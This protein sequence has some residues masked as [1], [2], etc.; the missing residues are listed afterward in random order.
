M[1]TAFRLAVT[2]A[3]SA[4]ILCAVWSI[5]LAHSSP[6]KLLQ[7]QGVVARDNER[8][9]TFR[10]IDAIFLILSL[11][12][13]GQFIFGGMRISLHLLAGYGDV[14]DGEWVSYADGLGIV[15]ASYGAFAFLSVVNDY[16]RLKMLQ[17]SCD[18]HPRS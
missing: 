7:M 9:R 3:L 16:A 6:S 14:E 5:W 4:P 11:I 13:Y 15:I 12:G 2:P 10:I 1:E 17:L 18:T 8:V